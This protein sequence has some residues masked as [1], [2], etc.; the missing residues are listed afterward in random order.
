MKKVVIVSPDTAYIPQSIA[1]GFRQKGWAATLHLFAPPGRQ[2]LYQM[3]IDRF[4]DPHCDKI[5]RRAFN[6]LLKLNVVSSLGANNPDL[7]LIIKGDRIDDDNRE[8]LI[9]SRV[10]IITW[11]L[12]SL[13]RA[14][15]QKLLGEISR[16]IFYIDGGDVP[17]EATNASWLPLGYDD[18][19][20]RPDRELRKDIDVLL[21]GKLGH[22]YR[23]REFILD[24]LNG[25]QLARQTNCGF[26]G[27]TGTLTGNLNLYFK[28]CLGRRT[29][30][31]WISKRIPAEQLA[32]QIA[33]AK[34][35]INVHQ[36]DGIMPVNP[37]FFAIPA[38]G[39]C[40]MAERKSYLH[41]WLTPGKDYAEFD[42]GN[43]LDVLA[44]L[45]ADEKKQDAQRS[46]G[47][48]STI[49]NTFA[50][51]VNALLAAL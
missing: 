10:P 35:C 23:H 24:K 4:L 48:N 33:R 50:C 28:H 2:H 51:R 38:S 40:Q 27:S 37:M 1:E 39:T 34:I 47:Y 14:P 41:R 26:I 49:E 13:S 25:S 9:K 11:T 19:I 22:R 17:L 12:D 18:S 16:H 45:L 46:N 5:M 7:L 36:D 6:E 20:Y 8:A 44:D 21:I 32:H 43:F 31:V 30:V 15:Y 3:A 29:G 42:D